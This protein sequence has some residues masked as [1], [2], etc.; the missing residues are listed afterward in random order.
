V[1]AYVEYFLEQYGAFCAGIGRVEFFGLA[2]QGVQFQ[3]SIPF[4]KAIF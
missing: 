3:F 2:A 1:K 4:F